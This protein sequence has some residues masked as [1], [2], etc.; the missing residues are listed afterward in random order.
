MKSNQ[1]PIS[2]SIKIRPQASYYERPEATGEDGDSSD[3]S[4]P[5]E[6]QE[7]LQCPIVKLLFELPPKY[8]ET[9]PSI[10]LL[11]CENLEDSE[12]EE[13]LKNLDDKC[14]QSLGNV[15]IFELLSDVVEWLSTKA[16]REA[17]RLARE[18]ERKL[19]LLE[20]EERRK[21]DGTQ[22][23]VETFMSWKAKFDAEML[24]LKLEEQKKFSE[25]APTGQK[26]LTGREMFETDKDLIESDL[27]FVDDLEQDQL[28]ALM[29]N[30]D[31]AELEDNDDE[32]DDDYDVDLASDGSSYEDDDDD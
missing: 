13:L 31:E 3:E 26:R 12:I 22:V 32:D 15:M 27:N 23:T 30:I 7:Q 8:P 2:F 11:N 24:K 14:E 19:E 25:Q 18:Q 6:E 29:Q 1:P 28:E 16:E 5:E 21:C 9:K 4:E 17:N 20:A 10:R